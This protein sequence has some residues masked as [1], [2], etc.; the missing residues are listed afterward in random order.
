MR[1]CIKVYLTHD[2]AL[3]IAARS[4]LNTV[5]IFGFATQEGV[6]LQTAPGEYDESVLVG[7]DTVVAAAGERGLKIIIALANNWDYTGN[8]SDS[9]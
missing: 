8:S 1:P 7:L 6:N 4:G 3:L 5:R 9:K 2:R